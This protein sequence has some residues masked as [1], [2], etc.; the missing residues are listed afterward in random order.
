MHR[1]F[2]SFTNTRKGEAQ[3]KK[4][5]E[6]SLPPFTIFS[7]FFLKYSQ[8]W[9]NRNKDRKYMGNKQICNQN[10]STVRKS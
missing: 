5:F 10:L 7:L 3:Q 8:Y 4:G 2:T 6:I 9:E 1:S